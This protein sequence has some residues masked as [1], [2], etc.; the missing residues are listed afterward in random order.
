M[1]NNGEKSVSELEA[2][3]E[4]S[5]ILA[6]NG[7]RMDTPVL[8]ITIGQVAGEMGDALASFGLPADRLEENDLTNLVEEIKEALT[9]ADILSWDMVVKDV[10]YD[11]LLKNTDL[12]TD[13]GVPEDDCP[14]DGDAQSALA[15][16]GFGTDEDYGLYEDPN[17][18]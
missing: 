4:V 7:Y 12:L 9:S 16:A 5:K 3:F 18:L 6:H 10:T 11:S 1:T 15:S 14:L 2:G 8:T 13:S 17:P